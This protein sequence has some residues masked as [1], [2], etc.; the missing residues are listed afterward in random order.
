[1]I[2][3]EDLNR[4]VAPAIRDFLNIPEFRLV[5]ANAGESRDVRRNLQG[6]SLRAAFAACFYCRDKRDC[7]CAAFLHSA[8]IGSKRRAL[9]VDGIVAES[10][11]GGL[12]QE[13]FAMGISLVLLERG[14]SPHCAAAR[15]RVRQPQLHDPI[16]VYAMGKVGST[17][18]FISLKR[19][20]LGVPLY[21]VHY[22]MTWTT[23][24][25]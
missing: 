22:L 2:R 1:M 13:F 4:V 19:L 23:K 16:I 15:F 18:A 14:I 6:I 17:S 25:S 8:G 21:H 7:I 11:Y 9:G 5:P 12:V 24:P 20:N 3:L 10:M